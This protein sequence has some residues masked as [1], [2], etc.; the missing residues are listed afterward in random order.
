MLFRSD[1]LD[2]R[3][4]DTATNTSPIKNVKW[5]P[6]GEVI[7]MTTMDSRIHLYNA[8][9]LNLQ[10]TLDGG[11]TGSSPRLAFSPDSTCLL[12]TD[13]EYCI[14]VY[15]LSTGAEI[16]RLE[17][18]N[19]VIWSV[20]YSPDG[21]RVATGADD[22]TARI[23]DAETFETLIVLDD[24]VGPVWKVAFTPDGSCLFVAQTDGTGAIFD[25]FDGSR[26][27]DIEGDNVDDASN[28]LQPP[29][30]LSPDGTKVIVN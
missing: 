5:S 14:R 19:G 12:S 7:V 17:G 11:N 4:I 18:H 25:S 21:K 28:A 23:W 29:A 13:F 1:T 20:T 30:V 9:S 15:V 27:H 8:A 16:G 22:G 26:L 24:L 2:Y 6:D 10:Q 3:I